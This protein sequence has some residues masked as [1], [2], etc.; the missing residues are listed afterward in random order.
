MN[1]KQSKI[2]NLG[3]GIGF[4]EPFRTDIFLNSDKIDFLEIT[5]DHYI[6]AKPEKLEELKLL[7]E[8]FAL[9][10]H[11]LE[12]SLGS[13]EGIDENYL[14]KVA[15]IVEF[16]QPEWFSDHICFT[17]SG[18]VKIGHLAPVPYTKESL[19]VFVNN[20][21]KVKKRI[22][23]PLI[24]EN[25]TYLMQFPSAEMSEAEFITKL[26]KETDCGLLLDVTNLY[27]NSRNF[28]FDW[29]KFLD[30]IPLERVVQLHY[31]G[32]HRH[33]KLLIDAHSDKTQ[34]E[35]WEVFGEVIKR[36]KPKGAILERDDN[37]PPFAEI[38]EEIEIA[39][40]IINNEFTRTAKSFGAA[41][42]G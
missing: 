19:K 20:I 1:L 7:K 3:V 13:A 31:V 26:L 28:G 29:R 5:T 35:I 32:L 11:S 38:L 25:I 37:F 4:R 41:L 40:S 36:C 27:I 6:D 34:N 14:E 15:E 9:I 17:K 33:Q 30:E 10:P 23:T 21:S 22:S 8:H 16:V 2:K 12:L 18:G 39:K 24:L 42:H